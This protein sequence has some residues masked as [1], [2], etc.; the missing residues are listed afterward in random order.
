MARA[1]RAP[2]I[3]I[4]APVSAVI[5]VLMMTQLE[6]DAFTTG[7]VWCLAALVVYAICRKVYGTSGEFTLDLAA[8]G[9]NDEPDDEERAKMD[10]EYRLWKIVVGTACVLALVLFAFPYLLV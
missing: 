10:R 3:K 9:A 1:Y 5:Y 7:I 8:S 4:G 2:G 6:P